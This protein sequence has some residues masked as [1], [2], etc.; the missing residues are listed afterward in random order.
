VTY[1]FLETKDA[2]ITAIGYIASSE[3][4]L[5]LVN[6]SNIWKDYIYYVFSEDDLRIV[7]LHSLAHLLSSL[8]Q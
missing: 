7:A 2:I 3:R 5:L 1:I 8:K 4:G 6:A